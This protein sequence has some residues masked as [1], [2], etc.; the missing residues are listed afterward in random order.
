MAAEAKHI[1]GESVER[2]KPLSLSQGGQPTHVRFPLA[3]RLVGHVRSGIGVDVSDLTHRRHDRAVNGV[4]A[5]QFVRAQPSGFAALA[6]EHPAGKAFG[7]LLLPSVWDE[8]SHV[9]AVLVP[10]TPQIM[11]FPLKG[12]KDFVNV[13]GIASTPWAFLEYSGIVRAKLPTPL[14]NGFIR[15]GDGLFGEKFFHPPE[16]GGRTGGTVRRRG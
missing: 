2:E 10:G 16:N 6:F 12:D 7:R 14:T 13:P 9:I 4:L 3:S 5:F 11:T 1:L 8:K 15:D